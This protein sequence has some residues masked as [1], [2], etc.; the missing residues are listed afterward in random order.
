MSIQIGEKNNR[1]TVIEILEHDNNGNAYVLCE[2]ECGNTKRVRYQHLKSGGVKSCGCLLRETSS[3]TAKKYLAGNN[4]LSNVTVEVGTTTF[5][6]LTTTK[7]LMYCDT[8]DWKKLKDNTWSKS[9]STGY[10][11][12]TDSNNKT[13]DFHRRILEC[14]PGMV[15][16]HINRNKLDNRKRNLRVTTPRVNSIN[17]EIRKDNTSGHK[18]VSFNNITGRWRSFISINGKCTFFKERDTYEE[19]VSVREE[20]ERKYYADV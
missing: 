14:P 20:A 7:E 4:K 1:L 17:T 3:E 8:D 9:P 5:V 13:T 19:A 12:T 18:G 16:D 11:R 2:C 10:A 6:E 15:R